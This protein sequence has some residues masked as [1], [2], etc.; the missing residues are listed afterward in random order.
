VT[1]LVPQPADAIAVQRAIA[2]VPGVGSVAPG[3][4]SPDG[5]VLRY[6][7]ALR[8]DA[9]SSAAAGTVAAIDRAVP[10]GQALTSG[11]VVADRDF[12]DLLRHDF[13]LVAGLVA[14]SILVILALMLRTITTPLYL[15]VTVGLSTAAAIGL[16]GLVSARFL[17]QPLYWPAPV[18][19]F[20]FLVALGED[21]NIFL[22]TRL[23]REAAAHGLAGIA[24]AVGATGGV[25][26]SCGLVMASAFLLLARSSLAIAEQ[27]G[28][29]VVI[30]VLLDTFL[31]RPVL[32][33]AVAALLRTE[34]RPAFAC[35]ATHTRAT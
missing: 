15:L 34:V 23:R 10:G 17:G 14:G 19:G 6:Q 24:R 32:V 1:V 4:A 8:D 31:V 3:Q 16:A 21:F 20:V 28:L 13:L 25:I 11:T 30:G 7:A 26:S 12:Q 5:A 22:I 33:P 18:F 2:R 35:E 27:I 9:S 29:V